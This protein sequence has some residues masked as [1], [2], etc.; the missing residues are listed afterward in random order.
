MSRSPD[1]LPALRDHA[2]AGLEDLVDLLS[3]GAGLGMA[4]ASPADARR[5]FHRVGSFD[6]AGLAAD[7]RRLS[8]AYRAVADQLHRLPEQQVRIGRGWVGDTGSGAVCA[9]IEHQRRAEADLH[10]LRTLAEATAAASAGID[11]L[12]R[13][14]YLTVARLS[15]PLVAGVPVAEVPAA[16]ATGRLPLGV[17]AED[18]SSRVTLYF[19]SAEATVRG[20]DAILDHLN[21]ATEDMDVQPYPGR[22]PAAPSVR[23]RRPESAEVVGSPVHPADEARPSQ[24]ESPQTAPPQTAPRVSPGPA[25]TPSMPSS[26]APDVATS[27]PDTDTDVPLRLRPP[28]SSD[29]PPVDV[30]PRPEPPAPAPVAPPIAEDAT[31]HGTTVPEHSEP[32]ASTGELALAGEE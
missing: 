15:A 30:P 2:V 32:P 18:I 24:T 19:T 20:I 28:S 22:S 21:R 23:P 8:V 6:P 31:R 9:V 16:V 5:P 13:T 7:S 14:W 17:V 4:M 12:L 10:V 26:D 27:I 25:A 29:T 1:S 11:Q 3:L